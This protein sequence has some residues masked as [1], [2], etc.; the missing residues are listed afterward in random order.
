MGMEFITE[1]KRQT[2]TR[3]RREE[4]MKRKAAHLDRV[5]VI[6][7]RANTEVAKLDRNKYLV[8]GDITFAQFV[9]YIRKRLKPND[10][11]PETTLW[12]FANNTTLPPTSMLMS[13][14]YAQEQNEED[15]F[16]YIV[17][18]KESTMG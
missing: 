16:L 8:P 3:Q 12:W 13:M 15:Q 11:E 6:V 5:P 7:D 9:W 14:L 2:T 18:S 17:Y 1:Y 10:L 4:V